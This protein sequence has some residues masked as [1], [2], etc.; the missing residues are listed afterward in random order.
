MRQDCDLKAGL[1]ASST[2]R[3]LLFRLPSTLSNTFLGSPAISEAASAMVMLV[4]LTSTGL[5]FVSIGTPLR[6]VTGSTQTA[7]SL[8]GQRG[9]LH[10]KSWEIGRVLGYALSIINWRDGWS[11]DRDSCRRK[12]RGL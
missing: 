7:D 12:S 1:G 3:W 9:S 8:R 4:S 11:R 2:R 5:I 6:P 10:D